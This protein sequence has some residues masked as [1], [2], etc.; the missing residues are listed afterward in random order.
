MVKA[1]KTEPKLDYEYETALLQQRHAEL[2]KQIADQ[3]KMLAEDMNTEA[4]LQAVE[5]IR[6]QME[7][8]QM[9]STDLTA[10]RDAQIQVL[11]DIQDPER[12]KVLIAE[13]RTE[14]GQT[15]RQLE[16]MINAG[17]SDYKIC[18]L[19]F[20]DGPTYYT[21]DFLDELKEHDV[22]ATFFT[23]G[24]SMPEAQGLRNTYLRRE[25]REGHTIANHTY[26]HA[27]NGSLYKSTAN[28]MDAVKRQDDLVYKVTGIHTDIVRFPAGSYYNPYRKSSIKALTDAGYGWM[29]WI[30]NAFDSGDNN[31]S[32]SRTAKIVI[33]QAR[34]EEIMVVLMHDRKRN[35]LGALDEIITTLQAEN[36]LFLPLFKESVTNGNC[37]PKWDD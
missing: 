11:T 30:G 7:Q 8:I 19:T 26:T 28:F 14:Y 23:I 29:D 35:T 4:H 24:K 27:I 25:A 17:E 9:E 16:D 32:A 2:N 10:Q 36:Y 12:M 3:K 34:Q 5:E 31:Y 15:V 6:Q 13:L 37:T 20:D 33:N 21:P 1:E 22:Y 18:Y